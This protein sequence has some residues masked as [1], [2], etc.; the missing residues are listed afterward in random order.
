MDIKQVF[1]FVVATVIA[2]FCAVYTVDSFGFQGPFSALVINW[3]AMSWVAIV[4]QFITFSF[5]SDFYRPK[6]FE[7]NGQVYERL[8]ISL[9]KKIVRRGPLSIFSPTIRMP[10]ERTISAL[11]SL[12]NEMR[13]AEAGHVVI[14][15]LMLLLTLYPLLQ[16]WLDTVFWMVLFNVLI[17]GYPIMLQRYNRI[18]LGV[19]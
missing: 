17:N 11:R 10:K 13:K 19:A 7:Q 14:L 6:P 15:V 8:G 12:D 5:G 18:K 4:G 16:G 3:I 1:A 2:V 9:F